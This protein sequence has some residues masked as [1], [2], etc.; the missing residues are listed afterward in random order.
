MQLASTVIMIFF[1]RKTHPNFILM[2]YLYR[3]P[4]M[5]AAILTLLM[6][7]SRIIKTSILALNDTSDMSVHSQISTNCNTRVTKCYK[8]VP[9]FCHVFL[10][11]PFVTNLYYTFKYNNVDLSHVKICGFIACN[12]FVE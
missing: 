2:M 3:F 12:K 8:F 5:R 4:F 1:S 11:E 10:G 9:Q 6:N 7:L